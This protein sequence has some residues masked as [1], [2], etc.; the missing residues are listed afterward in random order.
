CA[1]RKTIDIQ[2]AVSALERVVKEN[3]LFMRGLRR[4]TGATADSIGIAEPAAVIK[5]SSNVV[6]NSEEMLARLRRIAKNI[7]VIE[8][9][10]LA[11]FKKELD[12]ALADSAEIKINTYLA[13]MSRY[14][15]YM[16][17][18]E[19]QKM[20]RRSLGLGKSERIAYFSLEYGLSQ[21]LNIYSGGLGILSGDTL[22]AANDRYPKNTFVAMGL[23]YRTGFFE[24]HIVTE[25]D[26]KNGQY[27]DVPVGSQVQYYRDIPFEKYGDIAKDKNGKDIVIKVES[28]PGKFI[29]AK[30]WHI[31]VGRVDLYL[32][33]TDIP[34]NDD[35]TLNPEPN[36]RKLT[37]N[38]YARGR[39]HMGNILPKDMDYWRF[40]QELLLGVGGV[41]A[42]QAMGHK[43]AVLHMNEGHSALSG[44]ELIR[45]ELEARA[46]KIGLGLEDLN[47]QIKEG[48]VE[49]KVLME[50][51]I[52]FAAAREAVKERMAFTSHTP[53]PDGNEEFDIGMFRR[54]F[55]NYAGMNGMDIEDILGISSY[56][57]EVYGKYMVNLSKLALNLSRYA[58]GVSEK[59]GEV[60]R[61]L[62][63]DDT[64]DYIT[65]A[66]HR[67]FWQS[68]ELQTI[69]SESLTRS[70]RDGAI[71]QDR[72]L[73]ELSESELKTLLGGIDNE[74]LRQVFAQSRERAVEH[75]KESRGVELDKDAFVIVIA[76]RAA[77][78][79]RSDLILPKL[80]S[81]ME[82]AN[83]LGVKVQVVF[84]GKAHP[85]DER[86][87]GIIR[88]INEFIA[89]YPGT[90]FFVE[91][92]NIS[93]ARDLTRIASVWLNN[94]IPPLEAS[95]TSGMKAGL[96]GV[97]SL[98]TPDGWV[99]ESEGALAA[100][101]RGEPL[102]APGAAV[103]FKESDIDDP[104]ERDDQT[105][106]NM[107]SALLDLMKEFAGDK[108]RWTS[109]SKNVIYDVMA[110]FTMERFIREYEEKAYVPS[111]EAY[112][113]KAA[114][115]AVPIG[116]PRRISKEDFIKRYEGDYRNG[117]S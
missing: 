107:Y 106:E 37:H 24:Q 28:T 83:R 70:K 48:K 11:A 47:V 91:N 68:P 92:Y 52:T 20:I 12:A 62:Y 75:L 65:N 81:L 89:R 87:Q 27:A 88:Q 19:R 115:M 93:V 40:M 35:Q 13:L 67:R 10:E 29:Y 5:G 79:K 112:Q 66:V 98:S 53:I 2:P 41:R 109:R 105:R 76:R 31:R 77:P 59:H 117:H 58:N 56:E 3:G 100:L 26:H 97:V 90:A 63:K 42:L 110:H 99:L 61:R 104:K 51:G 1:S 111:I 44:I 22:W 14:Y 101:E 34:E 6:A 84:A 102:S 86:G 73:S 57:S 82:E 72:R 85:A 80:D 17:G 8:D 9:P 15:K 23:A 49:R 55:E 4:V 64:I 78:Y 95:G 32:L 60:S 18:D 46:A 114:T 21:W 94:P 96:N 43:V 74:A 71:P 113:T 45:Q 108:D 7:A 54:F 116:S 39:D 36:A 33:D 30:I 50:A 69:L 16:D 103:L 38:L 25:D